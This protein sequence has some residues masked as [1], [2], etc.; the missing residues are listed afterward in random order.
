VSVKEEEEEEEE[1]EE[2]SHRLLRSIATELL[3]PFCGA[4]RQGGGM[5][6]CPPP[7]IRHCTVLVTGP[8]VT[9]I[10]NRRFL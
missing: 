1:E 6:P 3:I 7:W 5:A 4:L 2:I 10:S 9:V 8:T